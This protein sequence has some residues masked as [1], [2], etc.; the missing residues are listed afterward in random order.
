MDIAL[1]SYFGLKSVKLEFGM[2][3]KKY[4]DELVSL[5]GNGMIKVVTGIRRCGKSYLLFNLFSSHLLQSGVGED[6]V[7]KIDLENYKNRSLRKPDLLYAYVEAQL[8]DKL[9]YYLLLD[10]VQMLESFEEVLN[11]F[12]H[13]EALDIYVT[14]SNA[15][16]LS[17]DV[18]TEFRGRGFEVRMNPLSFGEFM[19]EFG[20]TKQAGLGEYMLYG[21]LPQ[22]LSHKTEEAKVKFLT[23]LFSET[24]I[25]DI[26]ERYQVRND[27]DLEE[28]IDV[29]ASGIGCLTNPN[30]LADTFRSVKKSKIAY[31][32][33]KT[34]IDY[35]ADAFIIERSVRY[36]VKG[37]RYIDALYKYYFNDLGLRN[38][39]IGFR[40][41][42]KPHLMENLVYNELRMRGFNVDVGV[43]P[44]VRRN[45]NGN[46][47]RSQLEIDFVCNLGSRRYYVQVAYR[48]DSAEK[49]EQEAAS[50]LCVDDSFKKI[51]VVGEETP[52]LRS[53][54]G[55]VTM[56]IY[57]FLL[58]EN[59]LEL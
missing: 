22:I 4:L 3:R 43:V 36:D 32:T 13:I 10:E 17:R 59:S 53:E 41:T 25:R 35:L 57:D 52:V 37:K 45:G 21:G 15:K 58:Q 30:K 1:K 2:E 55:I 7:I 50:L 42:E 31:D 39:R 16:F 47:Y 46:Q 23:G 51:I 26:K 27:S 6:H 28:L 38:A 5:K 49:E 9:T 8:K 20:G 24:Y 33:V 19:Q 34:Y 56:S 11:G 40:Q 29:L 44:V 12:L 54:S 14:G 18:I 48:L